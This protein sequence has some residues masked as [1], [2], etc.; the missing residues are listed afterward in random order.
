MKKSLLLGILFGF[1]L[2]GFV[3]LQMSEKPVQAKERLT[4]S[5]EQKMSDSNIVKMELEAGT[6]TIE[7]YPDVA[8]NTVASFKKLIKKGFYDGLT[9][10]RVIPGFMAQGG[11]PDGTGMGGPGFSL[12][13]E[14]ND[15]K[16][17]RG[18]LAMARSSDPDSAGSQFYICYGPQPHLDGQYTIFGQVTDGMELVD[19]LHNGS[20]IKKV[21]LVEAGE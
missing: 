20:I 14:F 2:G 19:D 7:L 10:H 1:V 5:K 11:D 3:L 16:H 4:E 17:V 13:A 18:T 21:T 12:K 6:L 15:K 8:P 9:F